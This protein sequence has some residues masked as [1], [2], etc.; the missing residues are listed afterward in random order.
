MSFDV[1]DEFVFLDIGIWRAIDPEAVAWPSV[2]ISWHIQQGNTWKYSTGS[3][4]DSWDIVA[5]LMDVITDQECGTGDSIGSNTAHSCFYRVLHMWQVMC[6]VDIRWRGSDR[7]S[8]LS[9]HWACTSTKIEIRVIK[10]FYM[11]FITTCRLTKWCGLA[12][13]P[14]DCSLFVKWRFFFRHLWKK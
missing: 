4:L 6:F 1:C 13:F 5:S 9:T 3:W 8:Q 12:G 2:L 11:D 10:I 14:V 7:R